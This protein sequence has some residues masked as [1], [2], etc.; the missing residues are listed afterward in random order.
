MFIYFWRS[1]YMSYMTDNIC[2]LFLNKNF[3]RAKLIFIPFKKLC[4]WL[5]VW[6]ACV[7]Q[8]IAKFTWLQTIIE[9]YIHT[10]IF[11]TTL[12]SRLRLSVSWQPPNGHILLG[13]YMATA[14]PILPLLPGTSQPYREIFEDVN[15][16]QIAFTYVHTYT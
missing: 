10:R 4:T 12:K 6:T 14:T 2:D 15:F 3:L 8:E 13:F 5:Q 1:L 9:L 16:P 7:Q 11:I